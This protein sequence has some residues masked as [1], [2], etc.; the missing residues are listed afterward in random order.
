MAYADGGRGA[1]GMCRSGHGDAEPRRLGGATEKTPLPKGDAGTPAPYVRPRN[2][3]A[4][5]RD[6]RRSRA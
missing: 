1:A 5:D 2:P 4:Q 3:K 6:P